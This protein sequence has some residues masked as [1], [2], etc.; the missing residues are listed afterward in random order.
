MQ[1]YTRRRILLTRKG[2][3]QSE[4]IKKPTIKQRRLQYQKLSVVR[5][6]PTLAL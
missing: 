5:V 4:G 2:H 3:S 6:F 1:C